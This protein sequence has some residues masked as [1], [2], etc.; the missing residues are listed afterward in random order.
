MVLIIIYELKTGRSRE[1]ERG[2]VNSRTHQTMTLLSVKIANPSTDKSLI[3]VSLPENEVLF[4]FSAMSGMESLYLS[5]L[6]KKSVLTEV[7]RGLS[8]SGLWTQLD[9]FLMG[10]CSMYAGLF[11]PLQRQEGLL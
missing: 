7:L 8:L 2:S 5:L 4:P 11:S 6:G 1:R 9:L 10:N 3:S